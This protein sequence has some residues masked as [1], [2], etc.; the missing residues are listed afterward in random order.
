MLV[1]CLRGT[2]VLSTSTFAYRDGSLVLALRG[3][4]VAEDVMEADHGYPL[5]LSIDGNRTG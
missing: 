3:R 4:C 1:L 2:G 5:L